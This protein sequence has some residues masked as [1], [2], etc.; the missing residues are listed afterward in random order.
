MRRPWF[1]WHSVDVVDIGGVW[2]QRPQGNTWAEWP[3]RH[4]IRRSPSGACVTGDP[5]TH[6]PLHH[7]FILNLSEFSC[8]VFPDN[9]PLW[10]VTFGAS[11]L[12]SSHL[13]SIWWTSAAA[14]ETDSMENSNTLKPGMNLST[15]RV[16]GIRIESCLVPSY[17][18]GASGGSDSAK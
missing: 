12:L 8:E 4:I 1:C 5:L 9:S 15:Y 16:D 18:G 14:Q 6:L 17:C 2:L 7:L 3:E 11:V 13:K 10:V